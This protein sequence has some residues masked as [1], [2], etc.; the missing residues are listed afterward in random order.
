MNKPSSLR[1]ALNS[2]PYLSA[3]PD[4][5]H[6]FV[7]EGKVVSTGVPGLGWEYQYTLNM[8]VTDFSGDQ[9]LLTA[10]VLQWLTENQPDALQNPELRE[11]LFRFEVEILKNDLAD[12]SIYL[13]L[14]ERVLVT[15]RDGMATVEAVA[16]PDGP[17]SHD[18]YWLAH[19]G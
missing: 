12:I 14:T 6:L 15:V 18:E 4:A 19:H 8:V 1:S 13:A 9:N 11:R 2:I 16:E 10:V 17:A 5:L 3:N 7:D